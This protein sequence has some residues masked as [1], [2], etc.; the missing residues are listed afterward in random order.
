MADIT[1]C[2]N[3][4]CPFKDCERH[5]GKIKDAAMSGKGYVSVSDWGGTCR[6]YIS[7]IA[8]EVLAG[9]KKEHTAGR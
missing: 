8:E 9:G 1:Y 6:R 7:Y 2:T 4:S 5:S 3:T